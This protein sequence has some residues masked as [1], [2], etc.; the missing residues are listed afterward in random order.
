MWS[1]PLILSMLLS[2]DG[3]RAWSYDIYGICNYY[4]NEIGFYEYDDTNLAK[5][6]GNSQPYQTISPS[7]YGQVTTGGYHHIFQCSD[8]GSFHDN[9][10]R[11]YDESAGGPP[12]NGNLAI[13]WTNENFGY[14]IQACGYGIGEGDAV[15]IGWSGDSQECWDTGQKNNS[16]SPGDEKNYN[17]V[18]DPRGR[19]SFVEGTSIEDCPPQAQPSPGSAFSDSGGI[20]VSVETGNSDIS[21]ALT[22]GTSWG[23]SHTVTNGNQVEFGESLEASG[24]FFGAGGKLDLSASYRKTWQTAVTQMSTTTTTSTCTATCYESDLPAGFGAW[25]L[26]QWKSRGTRKE[27]QVELTAQGCDFL[28]MP[29]GQVPL[30]PHD[31]CEDKY[32]Q[33]CTCLADMVSQVRAATNTNWTAANSTMPQQYLRAT[34]SA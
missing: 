12:G 33:Q 20:W 34:I 5:A 26:Y 22:T 18:V 30:C 14:A 9:N 25:A 27:D 13:F 19:V 8:E 3:A 1:A 32:C 17:I 24:E 4:E 10:M 11:V 6:P 16:P 28:C 15:N 2:L 29:E 31:C 7:N 23:N 21:Y